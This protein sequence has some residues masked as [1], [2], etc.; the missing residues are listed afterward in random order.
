MGLIASDLRVRG[1]LAQVVQ[2]GQRQER[3]LVL[4]VH[5]PDPQP[6]PDHGADQIHEVIDTKEMACR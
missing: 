6:C 3:R 2:L 1:D 4:G 5:R